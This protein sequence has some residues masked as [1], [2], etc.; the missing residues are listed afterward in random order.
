MSRALL[1]VAVLICSTACGGGGSKS[2]VQ[3]P[4][5]TASNEQVLSNTQPASA[6]PAE[7]AT[8]NERAL[9][10]MKNFEGRMCGCPDADCA[11]RVSDEMTN[12]SQAEAQRQTE[13]V[14]LSEDEMKSAVDIGTHMAECM[15]RAMS[16]ASP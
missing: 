15:Q 3:E 10:A 16:A 14:K 13:P 5:S 12:W 4:A 9:A 1:V 6:T 8:P 11:K 7:P 2:N